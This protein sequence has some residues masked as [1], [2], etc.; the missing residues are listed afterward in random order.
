[1]SLSI[2]NII[3]VVTR[4]TPG[5]IGLANFGSAVAFVPQSDSDSGTFPVGFFDVTQV[6]EIDPDFLSTSETVKIA[7]AWFGVIPKPSALTFYV[8]DDA[9]IDATAVTAF[10]NAARNLRYWY[11]TI[12][13]NAIQIVPALIGAAATWVEASGDSFLAY[14]SIDVDVADSSETTDQASV[15]NGLG[16]RRVNTFWN[17]SNTYGAVSEAALLA[18]V[19][20]SAADSVID[21]NFK[22][23]TGLTA[24]DVT[25]DNV[26]AFNNKNVTYYPE[27][28]L[29]GQTIQ[30]RVINSMSHSSFNEA[31][32]EVFSIDALVNSVQVELFNVLDRA[33]S[34]VPQ[35]PAGQ[36]LLLRGARQ[37][38]ERF[39]TN[40]F[41]GPRNYVDPDDGIE[42]TSRGYEILTKPEDIL[43]ISDADRNAFKSAPI[44]IRTFPA[45]SVRVV[46]VTIDVE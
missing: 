42:K 26:L 4:I 35:T 28:D 14:S 36:E 6:S 23:L 40:G 17:S 25:A 16:L 45:G 10:L 24:D 7:N 34:K 43:T 46:D 1:M 33:L 13:D 22:V 21:T 18:T 27:I 38:C 5:G 30:G 37:G 32:F 15:F 19:N 8:Y 44:R 41:L 11:W 39:I 20:F 9:G 29:K 12:M 3:N 31:T 2:D